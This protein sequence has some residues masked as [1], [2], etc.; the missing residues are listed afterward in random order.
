TAGFPSD[1]LLN[2]GS[3]RLVYGI[4]LA[5]N[6]REILLERD[7][8]PKYLLESNPAV[9][10]TQLITR[11]WRERWLA[12]RIARPDVIEAVAAHT[13]SR[14]VTHGARVTKPDEE[15]GLPL[16]VGSDADGEAW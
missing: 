11:F 2:H 14:P 3:P 10:A 7:A 12:R 16:F 9:S 4:P 15:A 1:T 13:V 5:A 6:F 8:T